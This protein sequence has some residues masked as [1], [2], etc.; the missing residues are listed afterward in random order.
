MNWTEVITIILSILIP[1]FA[2]FGWVIN[3]IMELQ[4]NISEDLR[5][6]D[7]RLSRIEGYI[8]GKNDKII[9]K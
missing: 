3:K 1:M 9:G 5:S 8:E 2:G 6:L 4:K 7:K